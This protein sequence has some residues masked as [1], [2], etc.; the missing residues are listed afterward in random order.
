MDE[1]LYGR[2]LTDAELPAN[3]VVVK[4]C[5]ETP[6]MIVNAQTV[7]CQRCGTVTDKKVA[8]LPR[9]QYFCPSCLEL[10]R[11]STLTKLYHITEPNH[12]NADESP[13]T[14]Q[15]TL[16]PL[17]EQCAQEVK[18]C[19]TAHQEHLLWAVTGAGK[20]EMLF[21]AIE[22]ALQRGERLA[23]ASPRIDVCLELYPRLQRAFGH[24]KICLLHGRQTHP[25]AYTQL[26]ICTT[27][28]LL[29]FYHAFDNLIVDEVDAFPY[30]ANPQLFYATQQAVKPTGGCLYLT[31]TPGKE[32]LQ[33]VK[34][35][36]LTISYLP[37]RYH[38]HLLPTV[39]LKLVPGWRKKLPQGKLPTSL[40]KA[41][42][43][44]LTRRQRFLL[45]V[46]HVADLPAVQH[47]LEHTLATN[48]VTVHATDDH[49]LEKVQMMRDKQVPFIVTTSILERGVTFP[50]IDV[51]VLGADDAIFSTAALVQ[52]VGRA[53]RSLSRPTGD[54]IFWIAGVAGN[55][56][57]A[58]KQ[59]KFV[60]RKGRRLQ[61]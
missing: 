54:V 1:W 23:L 47:V 7:Q 46:P 22:A 30:A 29:R 4:H 10:G 32:L 13:L 21:P 56:T 25:Y 58:Q 26:T 48:V 36:E 28:Q 14:W 34:R 17:Q 59:I 3:F 2:R 43:Q 5:Q 9:D 27:H 45:F 35:H 40:I 39:Q 44:R 19:L 24:Q 20:T 52:I 37:L 15:G 51:L 55:V 38:G 41:I 61:P 16:S 8:Q 33:R 18:A 50:E 12:F 53:G 42:Q 6:A 31:A 60:N 49:R 11:I 57:A